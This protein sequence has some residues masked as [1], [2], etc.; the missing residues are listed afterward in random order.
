MSYDKVPPPLNFFYLGVLTSKIKQRNLPSQP[1]VNI[2][3]RKLYT[4]YQGTEGVVVLLK[5]L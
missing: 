3:A 2:R 1:C 5:L 4:L